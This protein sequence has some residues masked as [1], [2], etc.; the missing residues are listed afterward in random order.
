MS[1]KARNQSEYIPPYMMKYILQLFRGPCLE[2]V[3]DGGYIFPQFDNT[4]DNTFK[5]LLSWDD[6]RWRIHVPHGPRYVLLSMHHMALP[7]IQV[8]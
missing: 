7:Q 5:G 4:L 8:A 2:M 3:V 1:R 6:C